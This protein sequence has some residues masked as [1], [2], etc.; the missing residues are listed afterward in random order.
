MILAGSQQRALTE[1]GNTRR[2]N[3][4]V[5][6]K[7]EEHSAKTVSLDPI[8]MEERRIGRNSDGEEG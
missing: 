2:K 6:S 8:S 1:K 4:N 7:S 3:K 5:P